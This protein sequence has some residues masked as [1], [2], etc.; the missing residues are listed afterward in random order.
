MSR[1]A[2]LYRAVVTRPFDDFLPGDLIGRQTGYLSRSSAVDA[3]GLCPEGCAVVVRS[4]AV[5]FPEPER[6]APSQPELERLVKDA[7]E[8]VLARLS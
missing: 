7:V 1:P 6:R 8:T 2:Y 4:E 5:V 3:V